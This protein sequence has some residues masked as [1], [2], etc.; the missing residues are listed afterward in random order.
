MNKYTVKFGFSC[1]YS[2]VIPYESELQSAKKVIARLYQRG[3][4][5]ETNSDNDAIY[6]SMNK[7]E[8]LEVHKE[9]PDEK[10]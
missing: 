10:Q 8:W 2:M 6:V 7:V 5:L 4:H 1:G 9:E 3:G